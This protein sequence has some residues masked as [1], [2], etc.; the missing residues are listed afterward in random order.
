MTKKIHFHADNTFF[1]GSENMLIHFFHDH[2]LHQNYEMSFSF[3]DFP[4]YREGLMQRL[5]RAIPLFPLHFYD[6][7]NRALLP[8]YLPPKLKTAILRPARLLFN[9]LLFVRDVVVLFRLFRKIR[10]DILHLNNGAY[11]GAMSVRAAAVAGKLAGVQKVIMVVNNMTMPYSHYIRWKQYVTDQFVKACVDFFV[12]GSLA[13][14]DSLQKELRLPKRKLRPI[15]NGIPSLKPE[16]RRMRTN[17]IN[18]PMVFAMAAIFEERKGHLV[19]FDAVEILIRQ[20]PEY[21]GSFRLLVIGDGSRA[22]LLKEVV[23]QKQLD[24]YIHFTGAQQDYRTFLKPVDVLILPSL[25]YEDFPFVV[26]EA[27]SMA[28]PVIGTRVAGMPEQIDDGENGILCDPGKPEELAAAM[29]WFLQNPRQVKEMGAKGLDKFDRLFSLDKV[30]V[31]YYQL[32]RETNSSK[33]TIKNL[34]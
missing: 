15:Y 21:R 18:Q 25:A 11:P 24:E 30:L 8:D 27:M 2:R 13:A 12:T 6:L 33:C 7:H 3:N 34:K 32:Y 4:L 31:S 16:E 26:I 29:Y 9:G 28:R 5:K 20:Y 14:S 17:N 19:L 1:A 10:P 23:R 22:P